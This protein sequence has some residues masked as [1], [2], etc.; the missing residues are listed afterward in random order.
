[1]FHVEHKIKAVLF[2]YNGTL[3]F[4]ADINRIAWRQTIDEM[5]GGTLDFDTLQILVF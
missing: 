2:D 5:S 1:M 3:F 4:D